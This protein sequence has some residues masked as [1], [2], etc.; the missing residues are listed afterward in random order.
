MCNQGCEKKG[1]E[2]RTEDL[3][4]LPDGLPDGSG[5]T[6]LNGRCKHGPMMSFSHDGSVTDSSVAA[7]LLKNGLQESL[8]RSCGSL[9][10]EH[11]ATLRLGDGSPQFVAQ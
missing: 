5:P 7:Q 9:S 11:L 8:E 1:K 10:Q 4:K 3:A 2:A 6:K